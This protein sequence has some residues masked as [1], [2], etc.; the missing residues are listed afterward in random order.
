MKVSFALAGGSLAVGLVEGANAANGVV[1][2]DIQKKPPPPEAK[3]LGK[4]ASTYEEAVSNEEM[5]GGYFASCTLGTPPQD[6]TLQLDTGSS[7]IWVPESTAQVCRKSGGCTFGSCKS[8]SR[9]SLKSVRYPNSWQVTPSDSDTFRITGPDLFD[10]SYLDGSSARGDYFTD[11]FDIGGATVQNM[12]MGLGNQTDIGYGLVGVGY[13]LNEAIVGDTQSA[14]SAYP[15]LPITMVNEGLINTVAYSIWS[16]ID[17]SSGSILFGGIDTKKYHGDLARIDIYPTQRFYTSFKVAL[18]SL[19]ASSP[20]GSDALTSTSFPIPTVLDTGTTLSYL[21]TDI[22]M[23][24]WKEVG[25]IYSPEFEMAILP[26]NLAA[27]KGILTF[28]FA[29]PSGP[30]INVSMDELVLDLTTDEPPVFTSGKYKNQDAC[31]FGIQNFTQAP[32]LLG[33]TFLR[34]AYVVYDLINN[35]IGIAPTN[36]NSTESNIVPFPSA[37]AEIPSATPVPNQAQATIPPAVTSPAY[38][39]SPG[40]T[41]SAAGSRNQNAASGMPEAFGVLQL[42]ILGLSTMMIMVGSGVFLVLF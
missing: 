1:Q 3:R 30:K 37:S 18:T 6:L 2:W 13:A 24:V 12:T 23:Q 8:R 33:D 16:M 14:S 20:S 10:I 25:A 36:F 17:A 39:A 5:K 29:G 34:S 35:Q 32:Y 42:C 19:E 22:A 28:G 41:D 15:N 26:C 40:F 27:S 4:R 38:S 11:V 7:D 31:K 9:M 21:P